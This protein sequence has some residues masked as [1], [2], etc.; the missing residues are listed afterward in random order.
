V[1]DTG[2]ELQAGIDK[3]LSSLCAG[4]EFARDR[5]LKRKDRLLLVA[6]REDRAVTPSARLAPEVNSEMMWRRCPLPGAGVLRL[7][8]QTDRRG[9]RFRAKNRGAACST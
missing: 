6:D 4:V 7:V 8:D 9:A 2:V 5:A 1:N 3:L